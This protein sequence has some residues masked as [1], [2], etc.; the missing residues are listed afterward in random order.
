M[1]AT[2]R[3][4][5]VS[6]ARTMCCRA[7]AR[8]ASRSS[9]STPAK[10]D[11]D[12]LPHRR[13]QPAADRALATISSSQI[14][15]LR[16]RGRSPTENGV[17]VWS[18]T[19]DVA[20]P[21]STRTWSTAFPVLEAV[22][23]LEPGVY[24]M[25]A[26]PGRR[27]TR[28]P[29]RTTARSSP[30]NGSWSPISGSPPSPATDG[31]HALVQSLASAAPLA[32]VELRLIAR[33]N[34]VLA[35]KTTDADGQAHFDPG[36]RA[37]RGRLGAGPRWSPRR[38]DGD[39]GFLDLA[40]ERLRPHRPRR[41]GPRSRRAALDAFLYTE[42]GVYRSGETVFLTALLRDAKGAAMRPAAD[43]RRQAAGR[44]RI[45]ARTVD[46]QG[47]GG[48]ALRDAA[49]ARRGSRHMAR[50]QAYADPKGDT[51][52][53]TSF[54]LEDY[55]PERLD[56][57]AQAG[58]PVLDPGEP[59]EIDA[60]RALSLRR[61]RRRARRHRRDRLA[62][63]R[64]GGA[65]RASRAISSASQDEISSTIAEP[66][67]GQGTTDAQGPRRP[68]GAAATT[69]TRA[70]AAR[71][72]D[73]VRVGEPGGRTVERTVTLPIRPK[74]PVDRR[75]RSLRRRRRARARSRRS[76]RDRPLPTARASRARASTWSLYRSTNDYQWFNARRPL[77]LRAGQVDEAQSATDTVDIARRRA[78]QASR[79]RSTGARYRLDVETLDGSRRADQR[80]FTSAGAATT[81]ADTPD[82]A[83]GD[84]RQ[85]ELQRGREA[86]RPH[87]LRVSPARRRSRSSATS[88]DDLRTSTSPAGGNDGRRC[89]SR[90]DW[91]AG[92]YVVAL[93]HRPLDA[94]RK[95]MPGRALGARL[96]RDRPRRAHRSSVELD[97][98]GAGAPARASS[99]ILPIKVAGLA[100]GEE[101]RVTVAAVDVGILNLTALRD[102]GAAASISSA[103]ASSRTRSA[104]STAS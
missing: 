7:A 38:G 76:S 36:P 99:M 8:R 100:P 47:L 30:R 44:R 25:T 2:A 48:R 93:A 1:S 53:E 9:R 103:S 64:D 97:G 32:G 79:R 61:A 51:I 35:T 37:R 62:G 80:R 49:A 3:R 84:A 96:V 41:Q 85:G 29:T 66:T 72:Q 63:R 6:P 19:L 23:K 14:D 104:T 24:V 28:R 27:G 95:R 91:G 46:D 98:A 54:L 57:D 73:H 67:R 34:E 82:T 5:C 75:A 4:R 17:K 31:V 83:R 20:S 12:D 86:K 81:T 56:F 92:A 78:G 101:A 59:V 43:P 68:V 87:R 11:V 70:P 69:L 40:P 77:E 13:P 89:R 88:V 22:G 10:V 42:R 55:V 18:G 15:A 21:S 33:N 26:R 90:R 74:G 60:R 94:R 16:G 71:G 50:S 45:P 39:Y 102:A 65:R 58:E 52:G